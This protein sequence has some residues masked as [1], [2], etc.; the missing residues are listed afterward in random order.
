MPLMHLRSVANA[1]GKEQD[2]KDKQDESKP[3]S[4]YHGAAQVKSAATEQEH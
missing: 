2:E 1:T 3:T 4:A